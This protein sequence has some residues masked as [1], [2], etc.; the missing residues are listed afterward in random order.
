V[1]TSTFRVLIIGR[2]CWFS[3]WDRQRGRW[4]IVWVFK[5][6]SSSLFISL[7]LLFRLFLF[8]FLSH[9]IFNCILSALA[10]R[11]DFFSYS[12]W[13][14]RLGALFGVFFLSLLFLLFIDFLQLCWHLP[15][16]SINL[17]KP[18]FF[19]SVVSLFLFLIFFDLLFA[20]FGFLF[21]F[22]LESFFVV[23][24]VF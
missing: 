9:F 15:C 13:C 16:V 6:T 2:R 14:G 21:K 17:L 10:L 19:L 22:F 1:F 5:S 8:G 4:L 11:C 24:V 18:L 3:L 20:F 7:A 12:L 23:F